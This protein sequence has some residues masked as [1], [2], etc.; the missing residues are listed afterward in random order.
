MK[1]LDLQSLSGPETSA[2]ALASKSTTTS[3]IT[4]TTITTT[5]T[6]VDGG[7]EAPINA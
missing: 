6:T 3:V 4:V 2:Q 5:I 7:P 1:I